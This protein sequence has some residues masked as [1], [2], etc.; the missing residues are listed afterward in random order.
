[1]STVPN[2]LLWI[3]RALAI[4]V[5]LFI[6]LF[7][8]DAFGEGRGF[9]TSVAGF[10]VHL[11]PTFVLLATIAAAWRRP[12]IGGLVFLSLAAVYV[13]WAREHPNW[14]LAIAGPLTLVATLYFLS[15]WWPRTSQSAG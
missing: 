10:V 7:A 3:S 11:L 12:W 2:A 9:W 8:L 15:W 1:M 6:G 14:I 4:A 13:I 5:A